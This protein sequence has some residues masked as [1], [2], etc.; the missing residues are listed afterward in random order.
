MLSN[1]H[2][3]VKPIRV[4]TAEGWKRSQIKRK[5]N[6]AKLRVSEQKEMDSMSHNTQS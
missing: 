3:P 6:L 2:I 1:N 5:Q 4:Q